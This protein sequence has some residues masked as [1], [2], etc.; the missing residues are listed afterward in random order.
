MNTINNS[1][2]ELSERELNI[3]KNEAIQEDFLFDDEQ[4]LTYNKKV[5]DYSTTNASIIR[6]IV[7]HLLNIVICLIV[8]VLIWITD[9]VEI[10]KNT[11]SL[12]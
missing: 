7:Y 10:L 3:N 11:N 12:E 2:L 5:V 8:L 6:D 9:K 4:I 1:I